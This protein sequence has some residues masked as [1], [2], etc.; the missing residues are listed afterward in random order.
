MFWIQ[1]RDQETLQLKEVIFI[2]I[3][4][5]IKKSQQLSKILESFLLL[6]QNILTAH[7]LIT[8]QVLQPKIL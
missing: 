4:A 6:R 7:R 2:S 3:K 5:I 8:N 1:A